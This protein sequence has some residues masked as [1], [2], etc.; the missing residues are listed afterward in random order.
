M[1]PPYIVIITVFIFC[2]AIYC[3]LNSHMSYDMIA[4]TFSDFDMVGWVKKCP[5]L[6]VLSVLKGGGVESG[7]LSGKHCPKCNHRC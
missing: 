7:V 4:E 3:Q 1:K 5:G 2:F 6:D